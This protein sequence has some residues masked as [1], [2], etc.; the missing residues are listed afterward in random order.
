MQKYIWIVFVIAAV[1]Y[2]LTYV[3]TGHYVKKLK[4]PY[5]EDIEKTPQVGESQ[6]QTP[7]EKPLQ[8]TD[9]DSSG[10]TNA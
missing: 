3:L 1:G 8:E 7:Q 9:M 6:V 10:E 4:D 2:F 5:K